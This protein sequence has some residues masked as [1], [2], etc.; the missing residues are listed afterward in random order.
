MLTS[1]FKVLL[2]HNIVLFL[3]LCYIRYVVISVVTKQYKT[4][5][6]NSLGPEKLVC[7]NQVFCYQISLY[8]VSTVRTCIYITSTENDSVSITTILKMYM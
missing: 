3:Y 1:A 4:K 6:I 2:S 7:Y 8:R 5:E